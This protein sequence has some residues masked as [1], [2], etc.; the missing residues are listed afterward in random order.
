M[1]PLT[2]KLIESGLLDKHTIA[3]MQRWGQWDSGTIGNAV[4]ESSNPA[5]V[6]LKEMTEEGL[7]EFAEELSELLE[8]RSEIHETRLEMQV[9]EK[10]L[11][12]DHLG[13]SQEGYFDLAGNLIIPVPLRLRVH[14][15]SR[16][17]ANTQT[18]QVLDMDPVYQ[19]DEM[20]ALQVTV[21]EQ[22][23]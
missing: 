20:V 1:K 14:R 2:R 15:G 3:M 8:Q 13:K 6:S 17:R 22:S 21:T 16:L 12:H 19:N 18:Y 11:I 10:T 4:M 7:E 23:E 9:K 5:A